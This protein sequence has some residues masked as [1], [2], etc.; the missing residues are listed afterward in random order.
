MKSTQNLRIKNLLRTILYSV[1]M[2]MIAAVLFLIFTFFRTDLKDEIPFQ[3]LFQ[4]NYQIFALDIPAEIEFAGEK[5]PVEYFDVYES[6]DRELLIN[7]YWQSQTLLF[8]K[9]AHRFF[10]VIEPILKSNNI[11]DD[12]KYLAIAESGLTNSISP[13]GAVGFWQFL[14]GT[15]KDYGLI[16]NDE[17]DERYHLEKS[18]EA[19]CEFLHESYNTYNSWTMTAASYNAGRRGINNQLI[20]QKETD[21]YDLLLNEETARY[22]FRI[23]AIKAILENPEK[24]GFL[25]RTQDL[26]QPFSYYEVK[27][28][29]TID[30]F[31]EF[32]KSFGTNYKLLKFHNPWLRKPFLNIRNNQAY[33]IKIPQENSRIRPKKDVE[34]PQPFGN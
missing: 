11:P 3:S 23:L 21:Y 22:L 16:I 2:V 6:F 28:D 31:A 27:V 24:Y 19:A 18:T 34:D 7:T 15:A 20:I 1:S 29:S 25:Y 4:K 14:S 10:P 32:A 5:V 12:F 9:R 33:T 26:Y 17:V 8:I 13:A 30:D